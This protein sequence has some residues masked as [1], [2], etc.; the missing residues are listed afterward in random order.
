M[1]IL[2][3]V[4][5]ERIGEYRRRD[6][7][8]WLDLE[9][10][11]AQELDALRSALDLHPMAL[12]DT[13][14][15]GQR[16][17]VDTYED[18]VLVVF[19]TVV[20]DPGEPV[21]QPAEVHIYVSGHWIVT[22]HQVPLPQ[23]AELHGRLRPEKRR[24]EDYLVY[25]IFDGLTDAFYPA[26][27]RFEELIDDLEGEVL[28]RPRREHLRRI[29]RLRQDIHGLLRLLASQRDGF[30]ATMTAILELASLSRGAREYL[31]DI[32]DHLTQIDGELHRQNDDVLALTSTYFNASA[33]RLNRT[34]TRLSLVATFFVVWTLITGFFGQNFA[35]LVRNV[36]SERDFLIFG[37]GGLVVPTVILASVLWVKRHDWF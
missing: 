28:E 4:D 3:S 7:F 2:T 32:G 5:A 22:V 20:R 36:E 8:F 17:K 30:V 18:H 13:R 35:W 11:S 16:P 21:H 15:F 6:E 23:L 10:P 1:D 12:E 27:E 26:I 33:E 31:R 25:R 34:A 24:D 14:E 37:V 9:A 19:Y 29:Y